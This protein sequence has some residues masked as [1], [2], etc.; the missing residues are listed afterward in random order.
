MKLAKILRIARWEV[1]KNAG[2][3][4]RRT[5]GVVV[6]ALLLLLAVVPIV[7]FS[8][9]G[10]D[11]NLYRVGV[12]EES[13]FAPVVAEDETFAV[14]EGA[15]V[16]DL[17]SE[18][19]DLYVE[20]NQVHRVQSDKGAAAYEELR[21][22][23]AAYNERNL[24][25]EP[26]QSAAFPV[27]VIVSFEEQTGTSVVVGAPGGEEPLPDADQDEGEAES[28]VD[29]TDDG[30]PMD[31]DGDESPVD[32][33][34]V[35]DEESADDPSEEEPDDTGEETRTD[36]TDDDTATDDAD[37]EQ[38]AADDPESDEDHDPADDPA[39]ADREDGDE[40]TGPLADFL[41][42]LSDDGMSGSPAD[43]TPPFPFQ[44]LVLA[45]LFVLPLNFV[46]QAY[47]S[48]ILSERINRRGE[49]LLV[50]P[51]SRTEIIAGK[52]LP[53]LL[54]AMAL[55]SLLAVG[56]VWL[57][58]GE[59]GG[60]VSILALIP[61]VLLFLGSTFLGAMFAR[62][63][64]E[65]TFVT[66]TITVSL[67]SYAFIPAI[68][69][70]IDPIALISPL[71]LVV[72][73]LQTESI[74][75]SEFLFSAGPPTLVALVFF[76]LGAGLYR[77]ED[78]FDQRSMSGKVLDSLAGPIS[79]K[80]HV[81]LVTMM[82]IPFVMVTQLVAVATFFALGELAILLLFIV[83]AVTEELA[84]TLHVYAAYEHNRFERTARSAIVLGAISGTA[85]FLIEI[86]ILVFQLLGFTELEIGEALLL[87]SG[88][89]TGPSELLLLIP[90][91][92]LHIITAVIGTLGA[93][94][95][96]GAYI[97]AVSLAMLVHLVYNL[98]VVMLF[99]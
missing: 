67:T 91:L 90:P 21:D 74:A 3:V 28:P 4:D 9:V 19:I 51:V 97:V 99:V 73:D 24:R 84:K 8:G 72:R 86:A 71:T 16:D 14:I 69:S 66:V 80:W 35:P 75:L 11:D 54:G 50:T 93:Y 48:T 1:T 62:S 92:L 78:M 87:F 81:G 27:E 45:F 31:E 85:F 41:G 55:Q 65:L 38:E 58:R 22:S 17:E 79:S 40:L 96:K 52:T 23:V 56:A 53:Y 30:P 43:I 44:S 15:T 25:Q 37:D 70:D 2:G 98:S 83:V 42:P 47:G 6:V 63:F 68:F 46:I 94:R 76:S 34:D 61:L 7:A 77:E 32:E 95:S 64:K 12:S 10:L 5:L 33:E 60:F 39:T 20:G 26:N 89:I 18:R 82:L 88:V 59:I 13:E 49:L 57:L 36:E 29:D